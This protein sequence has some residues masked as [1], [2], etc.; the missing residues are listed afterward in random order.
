MADGDETVLAAVVI[1]GRVGFAFVGG[2]CRGHVEHRRGGCPGS[3][4]LRTRPACALRVEGLRVQ[5]GL[6]GRAGLAR[7][8]RHI[9]RAVNRSVEVVRAADEGQDFARARIE[10]DQRGVVDVLPGRA[11]A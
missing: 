2:E 5:E 6:E 7:R 9:D 3:R 8:E 10:R 1:F 11:L 4:Y